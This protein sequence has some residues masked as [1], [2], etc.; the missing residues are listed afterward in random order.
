[1]A[2]EPDAFELLHPEARAE[3]RAAVLWYREH[4]ANAIAFVADVARAIEGLALSP[5]RWPVLRNVTPLTRYRV[6]LTCPYTIFYRPVGDS[7]LVVAVA[8]QSREPLYWS[9]RH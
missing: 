7:I 8:H 4:S 5:G 3:L 6:L 2:A 9:H 1:M